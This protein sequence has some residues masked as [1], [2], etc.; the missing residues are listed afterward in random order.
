MEISMLTVRKFAKD[1]FRYY[2]S[3]MHNHRLVICLSSQLLILPHAAFIRIFYRFQHREIIA[4]L[5]R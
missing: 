3:I 1:R 2:V 4:L 5:N